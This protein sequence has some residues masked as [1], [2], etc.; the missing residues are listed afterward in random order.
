MRKQIQSVVESQ[1]AAFI[2]ALESHS[3]VMVG[4]INEKKHR[5]EQGFYK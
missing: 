2:A 5:F 4:D 1:C 3:K